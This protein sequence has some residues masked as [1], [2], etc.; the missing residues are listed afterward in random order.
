MQ[1]RFSNY[2]LFLFMTITLLTLLFHSACTPLSIENEKVVTLRIGTLKGPTGMGIIQ[3]FE[4]NEY[5]MSLMDKPSELYSQIVDGK[6]DIATIP[7]NMAARIYE[8]TNG[9]IQILAVNTLGVL[10]LVENGDT[11]HKL[12]D[13]KGKTVSISGVS[14]T[15]DFVLKYILSAVGL[16]PETDVTLD[17]K[18][19]HADLTTALIQ[20]EITIAILPQPFVNI[21]LSKNKSLR[22]AIDFNTEW[23]SITHDHLGLPMGCVVVNRNFAK[24]HPLIIKQF[25]E[26]YKKSVSF[27]N[28]SPKEASHLIYKHGII[29]SSS[30]AEKAIT[31]S[32]IVL[33]PADDARESLNHFFSL[34]CDFDPDSTGGFVPDDQIYYTMHE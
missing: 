8:K 27:V 12:T 1:H 4:K 18:L 29:N 7:T 22:I 16:N 32:Q 2:R 20:E 21:A 5:E 34:L 28:T 23:K 9:G 24:N 14:A 19:K 11:I 30:L 33:I 15:P 25:L 26:H 3:L 6:I 10:Y 13:L 31:Q 17:Y